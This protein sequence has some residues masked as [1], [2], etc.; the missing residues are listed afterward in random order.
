MLH[1]YCVPHI[2]AYSLPYSLPLHYYRNQHEMIFGQVQVLSSLLEYVIN[3]KCTDLS[4]LSQQLVVHPANPDKHTVFLFLWPNR[5]PP[6]DSPLLS[7]YYNQ[8]QIAAKR[9]HFYTLP[10]TFILI[11]ASYLKCVCVCLHPENYRWNICVCLS[12]GVWRLWIGF[13]ED[14]FSFG[15]PP[16]TCF[17]FYCSSSL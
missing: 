4:L 1:N 12:E 7:A 14:T 11:L 8:I 16:G 5:S 13:Q 6:S 10:H 2:R 17:G 15:R 3:P 9:K